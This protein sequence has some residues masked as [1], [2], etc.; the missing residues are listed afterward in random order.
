MLDGF[1]VWRFLDRDWLRAWRAGI[2]G[3]VFRLKTR[4]FTARRFLHIFAIARTFKQKC[5]VLWLLGGAVVRAGFEVLGGE[6]E[7]QRD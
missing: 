2:L 3:V 7:R 4:V 5:G 1:A 6:T